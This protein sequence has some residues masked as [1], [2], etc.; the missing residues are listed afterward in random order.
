MFCFCNI[1]WSSDKPHFIGL[2]FYFLKVNF[3]WHLFKC[4]HWKKI[5]FGAIDDGGVQPKQR[6]VPYIFE[7][8]KDC[9]II[10]EKAK[11]LPN[12]A[13]TS[14]CP[15]NPQYFLLSKNKERGVVRGLFWTLPK[16]Y[17]FCRAQAHRVNNQPNWVNTQ[18]GRCIAFCILVCLS[19]TKRATQ[20]E[21]D[22]VLFHKYIFGNLDLFYLL[23]NEQHEQ[24]QTMSFIVYIHCIYTVQGV[25]VTG[26]PP[27]STEKLIKFRLGVLGQFT[28]T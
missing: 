9:Q 5:P 18:W 2:D 12:Y 28:S 11:N 6:S 15:W 20:T 23:Q 14:I 3:Q 4:C 16:I 13:Q 8:R 21:T 27:K 7:R 22:E 19:F 17:P 10:W 25:F 26:A 1:L 24:K